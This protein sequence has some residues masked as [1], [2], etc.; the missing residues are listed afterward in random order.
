MMKNI[1]GLIKTIIIM[2]MIRKNSRGYQ[3][4]YNL[5]YNSLYSYH[6]CPKLPKKHIWFYLS[7]FEFFILIYALY[8]VVSYRH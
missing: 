4:K 5:Y 7:V 1:Y 8:D 3:I 6:K 2:V